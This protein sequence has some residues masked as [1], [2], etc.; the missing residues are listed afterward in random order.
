[1]NK[2]QYVKF[3]IAIYGVVEWS[4][5]RFSRSGG[6]TNV[7]PKSGNTSIKIFQLNSNGNKLCK[8][9]RSRP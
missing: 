3:E 1:M 9:T 2:K 6:E 5:G 4:E 7:E 8:L